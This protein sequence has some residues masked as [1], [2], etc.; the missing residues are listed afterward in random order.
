MLTLLTTT[1]ERP[2]AWKLCQHYMRRQ[3]YQGPVRW[4]IVDDGNE[5]QPIE[6]E[7]DGWVLD[8]IR[9]QPFWSRGRN[10]QSRNLLAGLDAV[11]AKE[12]LVFIEDDDWYG[13]NWLRVVDSMRD[14]A[15]LIGEKR[16]FYYNVAKRRYQQ[17]NNDSHASLCSTAISG[18]AIPRFKK[19]CETNPRFCD[20]VLWRLH[21]SKQL[22][23]GGNV[24]G[25][26]GLPGRG[27]IGMGHDAQRGFRPDPSLEILRNKIGSDAD[28]YLNFFEQE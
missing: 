10:T 15:E 20:I 11:G 28:F 16:A 27:G 5:P 12:T 26:K 2:I 19:I 23:D 8:V 4:I 14:T 18:S 21:P 25:M 1:G 3:T 13:E 22:F 17:L 24:V 7:R 9:P 6:F